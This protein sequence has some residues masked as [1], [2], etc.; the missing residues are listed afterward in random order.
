MSNFKPK[1]SIR[2]LSDNTHAAGKAENGGTVKIYHESGN[3]T[4]HIATA[5]H[6]GANVFKIK[7]HDPKYNNHNDK[8]TMNDGIQSHHKEIRQANAK[9]SGG[10]KI[11]TKVS[12]KS[13]A[14]KSPLSKMDAMIEQLEAL[15]K[16]RKSNELHDSGH[17]DAADKSKAVEDE[18]KDPLRKPPVSEAQ[19]RAMHAAARGES[20][21]GIPK[22]VGK[23]FAESDKGGK[24]PEKAKKEE[25][26]GGDLGEY[27][28][29]P[30][31][32]PKRSS[33]QGAAKPPKAPAAPAKEKTA[34]ETIRER[35]QQNKPTAPAKA[36]APS[37]PKTTSTGQ[38]AALETI[39]QRQKMS[40]SEVLS[41]ISVDTLT[42]SIRA[43]FSDS[44]IT[45]MMKAA[46]DLGKIHY[47]TFLEWQNFRKINPS[48]IGAYQEPS[49]GV[50][51]PSLSK[52]ETLASN[53]L[54]LVEW[55]NGDF[56]IIAGKD[57]P[58]KYV[59]FIAKSMCAKNNCEEVEDEEDEA[60]KKDRCWDGY[61]PTPGK[62]PYEK[63]SCQPV[64]K[65]EMSKAKDMAGDDVDSS[66]MMGDLKS[67]KKHTDE[68]M[69]HVDRDDVAPDWVKS[70][71]SESAAH[72]SAVADYVAGLS[73]SEQEE[74]F[75]KKKSFNLKAKHK[76]DK[77][78][79]TAEGR[80]AY[81]RATGSN[82]KA[83]QPQ[84]GPR[85]RSFC[86]RNKGQIDMHNID[87]KKTPE[88]RACKARRRW[89]C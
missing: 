75:E 74:Y 26:K 51:Q 80:K 78:G 86:A 22:S 4:K 37:A 88:K 19:R 34:L 9:P 2:Y 20:A 29:Q 57:V 81:N 41:S 8:A 76:S 49:Q 55:D 10:L 23:D 84:G 62:K 21:L 27:W 28:K 18:P 33:A 1:D 69:E 15:V 66:M 87:C 36:P 61:E 6:Q 24:L 14:S 42:K 71:V 58:E 47:T 79:L 53:E 82:L 45:E 67:I 77:G 60:K 89:K 17:Q 68:I 56:D 73:K 63:G 50:L 72:L 30:L 11:D 39:K 38:P 16:A 48:V 46:Y 7:T 12:V 13:A 43:Q 85:K 54:E 83:P 44:K 59:D 65:S 70:K 3:D 32:L 64:K 5:T 52:S 31:N 25:R 35:Q 40:K